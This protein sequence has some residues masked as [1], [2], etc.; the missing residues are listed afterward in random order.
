[1]LFISSIC[2]TSASVRT[3]DPTAPSVACRSTPWI[4]R[5]APLSENPVAGSNVTY[6]MPNVVLTLS[7]AAPPADRSVRARYRPGRLVDHRAG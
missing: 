4:F 2:R 6:R 1:M 5:Y 7:A 3:A